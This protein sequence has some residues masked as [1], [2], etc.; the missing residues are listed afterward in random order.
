MTN[1]EKF[2][3]LLRSTDREG[4]ESLITFLENS[5]F[6][7]APASTVFHNSFDGG[8]CEHCLNVYNNMLALKKQYA[9]KRMNDMQLDSI[10][11]VA[12]LH[13]LSKTNFYEKSI[14]NKKLYGPNGSKYD[15]LGNYDWVSVESY[16]V[17]EAKLRFVGFDHCV[18]SVLIAERYIKLTEAEKIAI[19]NHHCNIGTS[20]RNYDLSE[21]YS[22]S[23]L[24][25]CLH[26]ADMEAVYM[27]ENRYLNPNNI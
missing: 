8:L 2:I 6:F 18:D 14:Q 3:E 16:R 24:A 10:I 20:T 13:D 27:D 21:V 25:F 26:I 11:I 17:K 5:D 9:D 12:L 1:K 4:I 7:T 23:Q 22:R 15:N 19:I